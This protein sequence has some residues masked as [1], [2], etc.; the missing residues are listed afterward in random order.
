MSKKKNWKRPRSLITQ[1]NG[2]RFDHSDEEREFLKA[3][4]RYKIEMRRPYP[5]YPEV[6]AIA[7]SLGYRKVV[8]PENIG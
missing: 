8:S 3:I 7:L 6:L 1:I 5:T 2:M 4:D